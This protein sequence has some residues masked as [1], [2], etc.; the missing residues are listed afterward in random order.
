VILTP[1]TVDRTRNGT[2]SRRPPSYPVGLQLRPAPVSSSEPASL[3]MQLTNRARSLIWVFAMANGVNRFF[4]FPVG[5][6]PLKTDD[7]E[8]WK[9]P[10]GT[11]PTCR[12]LKHRTRQPLP[13][14]G[15]STDTNEPVYTAYLHVFFLRCICICIYSFL[16]SE[17]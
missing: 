4:F 17:F 5:V 15:N 9:L 2:W 8:Q 3:N 7:P 14:A 10:S 16:F 6:L 1:G 13:D 11:S 12:L